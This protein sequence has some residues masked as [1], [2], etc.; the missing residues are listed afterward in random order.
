MKS[1]VTVVNP[2]ELETVE[3]SFPDIVDI[4]N[5]EE[6]SLGAPAFG[7]ASKVM[8]EIPSSVET[9]I[10]V[11]D[12]PSL[13]GTVSLAVHG[14][15]SLD[16]DYI[17]IGLHGPETLEEARKV[18]QASVDAS[19]GS[20]LVV[21]GYADY[22]RIDSV[23]VEELPG[24]AAES[25]ADVVM[26]DTAVKDGNTL[27]DHLQVRR[28]EEFVDEAHDKELLAA[29][30]GSLSVEYVD[31]LRSTGADIFGVRGSVCSDGKRDT[32]ID[33]HR[34]ETFLEKF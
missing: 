32:S 21:A 1:L 30:S 16:P 4:K 19:D 8:E 15:S 22:D 20:N 29:V 13:P 12:V 23:P 7:T 5:P 14:A 6:G 25:G 11:G 3:E 26:I 18:V 10:A 2:R 27:T 28:I 9:S 17:K 24:I 31:Q 33:L 34:L